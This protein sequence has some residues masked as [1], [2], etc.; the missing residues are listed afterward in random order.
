MALIIP[1]S[2]KIVDRK[3]KKAMKIFYAKRTVLK[4]YTD[5]KK[6]KLFMYI[7][8]IS[9]E[10]PK[11]SHKPFNAIKFIKLY[12]ILLKEHRQ[13]RELFLNRFF[14]VKKYYLN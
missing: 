7:Y 6:Y 2:L 9:G 1:K 4:L 13:V 5:D 3:L 8:R 14:L 10:S 12:I 11:D